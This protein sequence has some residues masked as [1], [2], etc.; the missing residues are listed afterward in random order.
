[1]FA[2]IVSR[3]LLASQQ[4]RSHT[5][6]HVVHALLGKRV[7]ATHEAQWRTAAALLLVEVQHLGEKVALV[8]IVMHGEWC[9]T[10]G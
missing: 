5:R 3:V 2:F 4:V 6:Q 8:E 7:A 10:E 1:M 9:H